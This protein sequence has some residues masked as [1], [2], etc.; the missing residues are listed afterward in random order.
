MYKYKLPVEIGLPG[1]GCSSPKFGMLLLVLFA[2]DWSLAVVVKYSF[3]TDTIGAMDEL[4]WVSKEGVKC[5]MVIKISNAIF[6]PNIEKVN[7]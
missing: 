3:V 6:F 2:V 4:S 1:L 7:R 5:M